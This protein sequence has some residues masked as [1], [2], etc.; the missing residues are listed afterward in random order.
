[1]TDENEEVDVDIDVFEQSVTEQ[2]AS[3]D[4]RWELL[5]SSSMLSIEDAEILLRW[6]KASIITVVGER[7][8]GKTTLVA[9]LY[10]QFLRGPFAQ[11]LFSHS[12]SLQGFER[13]S[14][15]SRAEY[16]ADRP[17][18][19]RTSAQDGLAFFHIAVS[20]E[21]SLER[22]DL[23]ISE[24]AGETY[25]ELRDRPELAANLIEIRKAAAI[26]L[27]VDGQRVAEPRTRAGGI[28]F[29]SQYC[30]GTG[31][32]WRHWSSNADPARYHQMRLAN[33]R[34]DGGCLGSVDG[35]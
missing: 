31:G 13:K 34:W 33:G 6:R 8:G 20:D 27:I 14:F 26:V 30:S 25:R 24:R 2:A 23:L 5:P 32:F 35:V 18:T 9:Q 7:N 1:M 29:R 21:A 3:S 19:P 11:T 15:Q 28:C 17:D 10:E 12:L 16:G 22:T 4:L